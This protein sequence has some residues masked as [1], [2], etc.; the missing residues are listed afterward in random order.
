MSLFFED[1]K[2]PEP[3]PQVV[4]Q[5]PQW[6]PIALLMLVLTGI[7][8]LLSW[9]LKPLLT[10]LFTFEGR[11]SEQK[12]TQVA[13]ILVL[14]GGA[15]YALYRIPSVRDFV[16]LRPTHT[17]N[18]S[19]FGGRALF[20]DRSMFISEGQRRAFRAD[21]YGAVTYV[22]YAGYTKNSME[23]TE[24]GYCHLVPRTE[25]LGLSSRDTPVSAEGF[26]D[27]VEYTLVMSAADLKGWRYA[28]WILAH[29]SSFFKNKNE[30]AQTSIEINMT[31][32]W[33]EF[34]ANWDRLWTFPGGYK[35]FEVKALS[36]EHALICF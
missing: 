35:P 28:S 23:K 36:S 31:S 3:V 7:G 17:L 4:Q 5:Q 15:L 27:E 33:K 20:P 30:L 25:A 24:S 2:P 34:I 26:K 19:K 29:P 32:S 6:W 9:I 22:T 12:K 10:Y 11:T 1:T 8:I 16:T 18:Y 13:I 14:F 21:Q